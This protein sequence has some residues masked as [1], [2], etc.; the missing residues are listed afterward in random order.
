ML[1]L[2]KKFPTFLNKL[3]TIKIQNDSLNE[4]GKAKV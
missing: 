2:L 3:Y 4:S 1:A